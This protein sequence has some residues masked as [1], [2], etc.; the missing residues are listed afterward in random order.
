MILSFA[1]M[2]LGLVA[3]ILNPQPHPEQVIPLDQLPTALLAGNPL[4]VLD[5]GV[6]AL[7][8]IPAV[9][10]IVAAVSFGRR[11][12]RR[13]FRLTLLVLGLLAAGAALA[14]LRK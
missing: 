9:H 5:L 12:D 11:G 14:F 13:Y 1:L 7:M 8:A 2:G 3:Q 10:L 6:L 4:A